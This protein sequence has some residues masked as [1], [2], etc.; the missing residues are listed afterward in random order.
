MDNKLDWQACMVM[1]TG[2][3]VKENV[4]NFSVWATHR[5]NWQDSAKASLARTNL[6]RYMKWLQNE[7]GLGMVRVTE[8]V[9]LVSES[10]DYLMH[11]T[12]HNLQQQQ[13]QEQQRNASSPPPSPP[14]ASSSTGLPPPPPPQSMLSPLKIYTSAPPHSLPLSSSSSKYATQIPFSGAAGIVPMQRGTSGN[15]TSSA[16]A[17]PSTATSRGQNQSDDANARSNSSIREE[18]TKKK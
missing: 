6:V 3:N 7:I 15:V 10:E 18:E 8:N 17:L 2:I 13:Q 12:S 4:I 5:D 11:L 1:A 14:P 9:K 16:L